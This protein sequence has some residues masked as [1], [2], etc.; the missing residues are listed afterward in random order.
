MAFI[1]SGAVTG[2]RSAAFGEG[3]KVSISSRASHSRMTSARS[4]DVPSRRVCV[5][6]SYMYVAM[7]SLVT[8]SRSPPTT[9]SRS[10]TR[11]ASGTVRGTVAR[12][13]LIRAQSSRAVSRSRST[14]AP[15]SASSSIARWEL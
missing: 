14:R 6:S 9:T 8:T 12:H 7:P 1:S 11:P 5:R 4:C 13:P 2:S 3:H 10:G 15:A